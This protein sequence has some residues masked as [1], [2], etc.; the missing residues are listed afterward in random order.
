MEYP[1]RENLAIDK[2]RFIAPFY[3][4][5]AKL[6]FFNR[7]QRA[8]I[9]LNSY[10]KNQNKVLILGGG[11]AKFLKQYQI[12]SRQQ[13]DYIDASKTMLELAKKNTKYH[14][15][16]SYING[17]FLSI[18][19]TKYDCIVCHFFLDLFEVKELDKALSII[20]LHLENNGI[21]LVA[22][23][24]PPQ[25]RSQKIIEFA[26]IFFLKVFTKLKIKKLIDIQSR[27]EEIAKYKNI[28]TN[29][30]NKGFIFS[31]CYRKL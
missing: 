22:D 11:T 21:L 5:I 26:M 14:S 18:P 13:I 28:S 2:Y 8:Q 23:F 29:F 7:I 19:K 12:N 24:N 4:L 31:S 6:I 16:I 1:E 27:I 25:N 10:L 9:S 20:N 17:D 30:Y 3:D 15:Q